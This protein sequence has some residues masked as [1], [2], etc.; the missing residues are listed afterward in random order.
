M[1]LHSYIIV[2]RLVKNGDH[3]TAALMLLRVAKNIQQFPAHIVPILTSAVIE[4]QRAK[5]SAEAYQYACTLMRPEHRQSISEQYKRK[6][7]NIVRKQP[8]EESKESGEEST[9]C[10]YCGFVL[11]ASQ[12]DCP[13]CKNI[14]PFCI[15]T[16][17]RM[18][19]EDWSYCPHC[20]FA[21][22]RSQ[23]LLV[24]QEVGECP[25]CSHALT[26]AEVPS[27]AD[28]SSAIA[29]YKSLFQMREV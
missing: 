8:A 11:L 21:A 29:E 12:L 17:M 25:M 2:K 6:I 15:V 4:C 1:I 10:M 19:K 20:L 3:L 7:E 27:V 24:A 5:L 26:T 14:S 22:K 23:L 16:G 9:A 28:P 18:V 13:N